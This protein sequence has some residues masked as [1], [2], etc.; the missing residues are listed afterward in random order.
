MTH[1]GRRSTGVAVRGDSGRSYAVIVVCLSPVIAWSAAYAPGSYKRQQPQ[2]I[3]GCCTLAALLSPSRDF[4]A[5]V[6]DSQ[7]A[8]RIVIGRRMRDQTL[9]T[10]VTSRQRAHRSR[11]ARNGRNLKMA[12]LSHYKYV[13]GFHRPWRRTTARHGQSARR[14]ADA[15]ALK[16]LFR[17]LHAFN[18]ALDTRF[19]L[20][21]GGKRSSI[22]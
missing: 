9:A 12:P 8:K 18:A 4:T 16:V 6:A 22:S 1:G 20:L 5:P 2:R 11:T 15:A 21:H 17:R 13:P 7:S 19:A 14:A 3:G 10:T